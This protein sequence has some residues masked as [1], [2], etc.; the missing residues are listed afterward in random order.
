MA[1]AQQI[2]TDVLAT[3]EQIA[4]GFL[5]VGGNVNGGEC[6]GAIEDGQMA[7][8]ATIGFDAV[9]GPSRNERRGNDVARHLPRDEKSLQLKAARPRL[10]AAPHRLVGRQTRDEPPNGREIRRERLDRGRPLAWEQH[11]GDD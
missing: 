9:S 2:G 5:L 11:G 8:V 10:I 3:A 4:R 6:A 1:S 7:G